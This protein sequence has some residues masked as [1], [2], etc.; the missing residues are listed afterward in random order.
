MPRVQ[1][2]YSDRDLAK[3]V[4]LQNAGNFSTYKEL[5]ASAL[6]LVFWVVREVRNGRK[7]GSLDEKNDRF[8]ELVMPFMEHVGT[9]QPEPESAIK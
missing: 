8:V 7:V 9:P 2:D 1:L 5:F 3:I 4:E 6:T